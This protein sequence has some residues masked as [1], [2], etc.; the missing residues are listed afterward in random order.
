M[1]IFFIIT[2]ITSLTLNGRCQTLKMELVTRSEEREGIFRKFSYSADDSYGIINLVLMKDSTFIY[3][4]KTFNTHGTSTGKW[5]FQQDI[6]ILTST[7]QKDNI[8][9]TLSAENGRKFVDSSVIAVVENEK[10]ELI[11]DAFVLV[12]EDS[13]KC[14]PATALC[15]GEFKKIYRVKVLFENGMSSQWLSVPDDQSRIALTV[16]TDIDITN[17]IIMTDQRF[18][19]KGKYLSQQ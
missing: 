18:C 12:N 10:K 13:I 15:N 17:Y 7:L 8:P 19:M 5:T 6:I 1:K 3:R 9:V 4:T 16:L 11:T 2:L 14:L